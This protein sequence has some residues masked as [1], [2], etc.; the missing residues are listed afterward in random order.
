MDIINEEKD[1]LF[2]ETKI[3]FENEAFNKE[4]LDQVEHNI[5]YCINTHF[6]KRQRILQEPLDKLRSMTIETPDFRLLEA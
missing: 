4:S 3:C 2:D 6:T 5:N 1:K